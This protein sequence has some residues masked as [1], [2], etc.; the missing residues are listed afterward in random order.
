[1]LSMW[2][3]VFGALLLG[4]TSVLVGSRLDSGF[5]ERLGGFSV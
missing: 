2:D 3:L 4:F 1:M 5:V